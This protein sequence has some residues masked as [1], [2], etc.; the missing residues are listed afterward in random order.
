M[1]AS[2]VP[3]ERERDQFGGDLPHFYTRKDLSDDFKRKM[4]YDT[5]VRF[6]HFSEGDIAAAKKNK[7]N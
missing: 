4:L 5:P 7:G 1:W 6:Y 2:D 3:H